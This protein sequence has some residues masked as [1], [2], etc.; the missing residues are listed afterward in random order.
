MKIKVR[1]LMTFSQLAGKRAEELDIAEGSTIGKLVERLCRIHGKNF[2][3][4]LRDSLKNNTAAFL[5]NGE[6]ASMEDALV[7]GDEVTV[8]HIVGGG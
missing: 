2:G 4:Y 7:R 8:S 1:Y 6:V 3:K 5:R